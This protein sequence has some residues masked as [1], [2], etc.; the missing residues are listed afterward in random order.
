MTEFRLTPVR[1][2]DG[3][4]QAS[5]L[6]IDNGRLRYAYRTEILR[7]TE[8]DALADGQEECEEMRSQS[9]GLVFND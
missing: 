2:E 3:T 6:I 5:I 1:N 4:W 9:R 8:A 7:L